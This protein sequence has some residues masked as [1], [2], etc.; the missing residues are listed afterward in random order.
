MA[1]LTVPPA[2]DRGGVPEADRGDCIRRLPFDEYEFM[3]INYS[4]IIVNAVLALSAN[5]FLY[6]FSRF[7]IVNFNY[8]LRSGYG[9]YMKIVI[10]PLSIIAIFYMLGL[11]VFSYIRRGD[12]L[13]FFRNSNMKYSWGYGSSMAWTFLALNMILLPMIAYC[14]FSLPIVSFIVIYIISALFGFSLAMESKFE[15]SAVGMNASLEKELRYYF[16]DAISNHLPLLLLLC[17]GF[18]P[19]EYLMDNY[20]VSWVYKLLVLLPLLVPVL[21]ASKFLSKRVFSLIDLKKSMP[22]YTRYCLFVIPILSICLFQSWELFITSESV[23]GSTEQSSVFLIMLFTGIIPI[24]LLYIYEPDIHVTNRVITILCLV[25][26]G[27]S[28]YINS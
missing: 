23:L 17:C 13:F 15:N 22:N 12:S 7:G 16:D 2:G 1:S 11:P 14:C 21:Y 19:L 9:I 28:K 5:V 8:Y 20:G 3:K 26:Y 24:R 4:D 25:V 6:V 27:A 10:F 18:F